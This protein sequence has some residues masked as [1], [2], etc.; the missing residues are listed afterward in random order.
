M[1]IRVQIEEAANQTMSDKKDI[2]DE[3]KRQQ[4][5]QQ[6]E[7]KK[8]V[9]ARDEANQKRLIAKLQRDKNAGVKDLQKQEEDQQETNDSFAN[10]LVVE[11][12]KHDKLRDELM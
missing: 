1:A 7:L 5:E 12:D 3:Q 9:L 4:E 8:Q 11:T 2:L 6:E 10:K